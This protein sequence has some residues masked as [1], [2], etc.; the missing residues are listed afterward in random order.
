MPSTSI[1]DLRK[2]IARYEAKLKIL[3]GEGYQQTYRVSDGTTQTTRVNGVKPLDDFR[4]EIETLA[5]WIW[6]LKD[7]LK[8]IVQG[9]GKDPR[10]VEIYVDSCWNLKVCSDLANGAKHNRLRTSRSKLFAKL[11]DVGME[12]PGK[13]LEKITVLANELV[14]DIKD[15]S[16]AEYEAPV[17]DK[18]GCLIGDA[19]EILSCAMQDWEVAILRFK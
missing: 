7:Y 15:A 3:H 1:E 9:N 13:S 11:M 4:D 18:D 6:S 16:Q 12:I 8:E 5:I 17:E 14:F 2:R 10:Y 19:V